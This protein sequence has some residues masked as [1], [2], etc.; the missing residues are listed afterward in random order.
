MVLKKFWNKA[1]EYYCTAK[2]SNSIENFDTIFIAVSEDSLEKIK[3]RFI[4]NYGLTQIEVEL[5]EKNIVNA[6]GTI[7]SY[8]D[9]C[10]QAHNKLNN[11]EKYSFLRFSI[12]VVG[13]FKQDD[14]PLKNYWKY[15]DPFLAE[16]GIS[17]IHTNERTQYLNKLI[18][19]L[20]KW[21][22]LTH[23]KTFF[24]LNVFGENSN[25]VN[26]GRIKAHSVFQ[27]RT[28]REIKKTI[29]YLGYADSH[30]IEDLNYS[31]IETILKESN[32]KRILN[33]FNRDEDAREIVFQCL[34]IWLDKWAP[35]QDEKNRLL[36]GLTTS[37]KALISIQRLW[38][39]NYANKNTSIEY[40]F[41]YM[42]SLGE[43]SIFYLNKNEDVY[44]ETEWGIKLGKNRYLYIIKNYSDKIDLN[45]NE[46][47][48]K[49]KNINKDLNE[50][51][52]SLEQVPKRKIFIENLNK[53]VLIKDNPVMIAAK[54]EVKD[55]SDWF[56]GDFPTEEEKQLFKLYRVTESFQYLKHSFVK[57]NNLN[58]I[59]LGITDGRSGSKSFL[60]SFPVKIHIGNTTDG[61]IQ[62]LQEE[63]IKYKFKLTEVTKNLNS[64][65]KLGLIPPGLY[66][67]KYYDRHN[68]CLR[69]KT[70]NEFIKF[71]VVENG[72]GDRRVDRNKQALTPF[73][74][75]EFRWLKSFEEVE[76]SYVIFLNNDEQ[77]VFENKHTDFYFSQN[78]RKEWIIKPNSKI[79]YLQR[80]IAKPINIALHYNTWVIDMCYLS[81]NFKQYNYKIKFCV[82]PERLKLPFE[83]N[84]FHL[85]NEE[86]KISNDY[87]FVDCYY[88]KLI[89][90]DDS[91]RVEY[92]NI[93]IG[94]E[95]FIISNK[96]EINKPENLLKLVNQEFFPFK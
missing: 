35:S 42:S 47:G 38:C 12:L 85:K 86:C 69:F 26:V 7:K 2:M 15:F 95:I 8:Y 22:Y 29:Y 53:R 67:I 31:D 83:P 51:A 49:F 21:C 17:L 33:L 61:E 11:P 82:R 40:G 36:N 46:L 62:V 89:D 84:K 72:L 54:S 44:I 58:I 79:T 18:S 78:T 56:F 71:E 77:L 9:A 48:L 10:K 19:N 73:K 30:S 32:L 45:Q 4:S 90:L 70:G 3:K 13:A 64:E 94:D 63:V 16:K 23:N 28:L 93:S 68:K 91:L 60:S 34:K 25:I 37:K 88:Y 87:I 27:G 1:I 20:S 74:Y 41:I 96:R 81:T 43:E 39:F 80:T 65:I 6:G 24:Q 76:D 52:Y 75:H 66:S 59:P 92:P 50:K 55:L 5:S 14:S 57:T